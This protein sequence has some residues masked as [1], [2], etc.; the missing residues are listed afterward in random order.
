MIIIEGVT[1]VYGGAAGKKQSI[2]YF[3]LAQTGVVPGSCVGT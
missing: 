3:L 2:S 1:Q